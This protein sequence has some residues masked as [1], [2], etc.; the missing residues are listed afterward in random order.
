MYE[1]K[2]PNCMYK[3]LQYPTDVKDLDPNAHIKILKKAIKDNGET[4][5]VD[6]INMFGFIF[7]N[8]LF[9]WNDFFQDHPSSTFEELD[10]AFCKWF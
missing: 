8:S 6:L 1:S 2:Q 10:E 5:E 7:K 9:E 3:K 4:M